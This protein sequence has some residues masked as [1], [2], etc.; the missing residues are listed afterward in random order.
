MTPEHSFE[1][2]LSNDPSNDWRG[3]QTLSTFGQG[4][5]GQP[6]M[7]LQT[8]PGGKGRVVF[9]ETLMNGVGLSVE[10]L[11]DAMKQAHGANQMRSPYDDQRFLSKSAVFEEQHLGKTNTMM[12]EGFLEQGFSS[13]VWLGN[14]AAFP[15]LPKAQAF[16]QFVKENLPRALAHFPE[17]LGEVG[18]KLRRAGL[19]VP[20]SSTPALPLNEVV[21]RYEARQ[22]GPG[23]PAPS[24]A[25][26]GL[27]R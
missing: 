15:Q 17:E 20:A 11:R 10:N 5:N 26:R 2:H 18:S 24:T 19:P 12:F 23:Q 16:F 22:N 14:A 1:I 4:P 21:E 27:K 8:T 13:R 9:N 7:A 3:A 6:L 25:P